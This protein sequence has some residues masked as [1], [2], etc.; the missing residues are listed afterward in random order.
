LTL[1]EYPELKDSWYGQLHHNMFCNLKSLVVQKCEFLSH[2]LF[3]SNVIQ[4]LHGLENLEVRD[5][6]SLE[7]LFD[8]KG[9]KS[10]QIL[11][12]QTSQLKTLTLSGSPN[13]KHIWNKDPYEI[14]SFGKLSTV[15]ISL[16]QS[17]LYIFPLSLCEDL[18]NL[19]MLVI[20]SSGVEQIVAMEDTTSTK[21]IITFPQLTK[22]L[23]HH[24]E[25]LT[26]FCP[27]KH[28][29]ECPSLKILDVNHCEGL[30]MF[31]FNRFNIQQCDDILIGQALFS[32]E[33]VTPTMP[34]LYYF[35]KHL[36]CLLYS[37][38]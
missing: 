9:L 18:G 34:Y 37:S 15:D 11:I 38:K 28:T 5:C 36:S 2:V 20:E 10:K 32:I 19:K 1:S 14:I 26:S 27:R 6:D 22:F 17:L 30:T 29:L 33:K 24:L 4:V 21:N 35:S 3:P 31:S 7:A 23:L 12:K 25:K 16:C 8:V 13:L